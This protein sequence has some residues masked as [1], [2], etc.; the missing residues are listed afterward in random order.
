MSDQKYLEKVDALIAAIAGTGIVEIEV[1][2]PQLRIHIVMAQP[3]LQ[4]AAPLFTASAALSAERDVSPA[5]AVT[6][7]SPGSDFTLASD[8]TV[9]E[10]PSYGQFHHA[11][12][13]GAPPFVAVGH[14]VSAGQE[15]A[16]MEAM[17]VFTPLR[18][19]IDGIV[20]EILVD[21]GRD[22]AP[23]QALMR[24]ERRGAEATS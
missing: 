8:F 3:P 15:L 11:P 6:N 24:I 22:V 13:P 4:D 18:S 5:A 9:L 19:P 14:T 17:K 1:A 20:R 2:E 21:N 16:I 12:A 23:G 10:A 7:F